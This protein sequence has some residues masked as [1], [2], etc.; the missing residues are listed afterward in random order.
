MMKYQIKRVWMDLVLAGLLGL[1]FV[2]GFYERFPAP[3]QLAALKIALVSMAFLHAHIV[4]K[5]AFP[6]AM[7]GER[8]DK[9]DYVKILRI[10]LYATFVIAYSIGG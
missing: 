10:T 1:F 7:W 6:P 8:T 5:L 2:T 4:G 3:T 9:T